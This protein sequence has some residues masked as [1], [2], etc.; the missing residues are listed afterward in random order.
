[1]LLTLVRNLSI[2]LMLTLHLIFYD[3]VGFCQIWVPLK[4]LVI[5]FIVT[6]K[7][8]YRFVIMMFSMRIPNIS[9]LIVIS[10]GTIFNKAPCFFTPSP[11]KT[12]L[13]TFSQNLIH[14]TD[15]VIFIPNSSCVHHLE[16]EGDVD[17]YLIRILIWSG[18]LVFVYL[19]ISIGLVFFL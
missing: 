12:S 16:F 1:M 18:D 9:R 10:L 14:P 8:P 2:M 3:Y 17:I 4:R 11:L 7:V 15:F 5:L 19:F 13:P 6:I